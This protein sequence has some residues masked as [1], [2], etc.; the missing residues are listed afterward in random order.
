LMRGQPG[1]AGC[2][3]APAAARSRRHRPAAIPVSVRI[4][5]HRAG[6]AAGLKKPLH[7]VFDFKFVRSRLLSKIAWDVRRWRRQGDGPESRRKKEALHLCRRQCLQERL[8]GSSIIL[9]GEPIREPP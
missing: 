9:S 3:A 1:A 7:G 5:V 6:V 4:G 2:S 8:D